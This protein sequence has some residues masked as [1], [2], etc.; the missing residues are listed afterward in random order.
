V[1]DGRRGHRLIILVV[2]ELTVV[3]VVLRRMIDS[4]S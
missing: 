2:S 3:M 4:I 1:V